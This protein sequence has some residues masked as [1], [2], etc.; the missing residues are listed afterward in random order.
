MG[1]WR[2]GLDVVVTLKPCMKVGVE[3]GVKGQRAGV[4]S[5]SNNGALLSPTFNKTVSTQAA[6][7]RK[8]KTP[9]VIGCM[10][11]LQSKVNT[12]T[13]NTCGSS[14]SGCEQQVEPPPPSPVQ[15]LQAEELESDTL[16]PYTPPHIQQLTI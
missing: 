9:T 5:Q 11:S 6:R 16:A 8:I 7:G 13:G 1:A 12:G 3:P 2:K 14:S 4:T 15:Q 10:I